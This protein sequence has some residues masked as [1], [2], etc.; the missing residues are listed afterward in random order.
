MARQHT[1]ASLVRALGVWGLAA[2]IVNITIGGGIFRLPAAAANALG[3]AAPVAYAVCAVAMALIVLCFAEAGSRV[4][5]TGGVYAY[6][7]IAFGPLF[8]FVTGVLMWAGIT[9][10]TAAVSSLFA[11]AMVALVPSLAGVRGAAISLILI[12]L[13]LLNIAGVRG[14]NRFVEV[15]TVAKL[16]PLLLLIV[17]GIAAVR[18]QNLVVSHAPAVSQVARASIVSI[19]AFLGVESALVPGGE[20]RDP[21]RT[22][23]RAVFLAMGTIVLV[24]FAVQIVAQGVL[25]PALATAKTPLADAAAV[26][27]GSWGR[28]TILVGMVVSMFGYL[29]GMTLAVPRTLY[30]FARD[31]FLP[32]PIAA[33]HARF[34]TPYVAIVL[35]TLVVIALAVSGTFEKLAI[36][37][38]GT[39]LLVYA[40]C[41]VAVVQL[42]RLDVKTDGAPFRVPF[43][44]VVPVLAFAVVVALLA[45][46]SADEWKAL[47][48]I[49]GVGVVVFAA[50]M[51]NRRARQNASRAG[52]QT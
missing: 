7:E 41:C 17:G 10:A 51:S 1:E 22:V 3:A 36:I 20:V 16:L 39:I 5:L 25:G 12:A 40:A 48:A 8:G 6:V 19:F 13:A 50:S 27:F 52:A 14:A 38:N 4:S 15:M 29:S 31:G 30:A 9:V 33:V 26:A 49:A 42:R 34:R 23:P 2:S 35:Q 43:S 11:D 28:T 44:G 32:A 47:L 45:T 24:Y 21:S 46:L 18:T 37:S